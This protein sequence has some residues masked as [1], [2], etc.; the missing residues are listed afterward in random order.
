MLG[1]HEG[2]PVS[3]APQMARMCMPHWNFVSASA[4]VS[5]MVFVVTC[6]AIVGAS[7]RLVV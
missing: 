5:G 7:K 2:W 6:C 1:P 3:W 4:M